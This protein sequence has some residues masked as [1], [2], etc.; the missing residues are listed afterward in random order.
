MSDN[1][2]K[3]FHLPYLLWIEDPKNDD[4]QPR[5]NTPDPVWASSISIRRR[6]VQQLLDDL[7][8]FLTVMALS[9][10]RV[11]TV[12]YSPSVESEWLRLNVVDN[13]Y[14]VL[15]QDA[16]DQQLGELF[17]CT[18][19][20]FS[21]IGA[22]PLESPFENG[23]NQT[24]ST[25]AGIDFTGWTEDDADLFSENLYQLM[26]LL[27]D[28]AVRT[29]R[30]HSTP[31]EAE[32]PTFKQIL[33]AIAKTVV[34]VVWFLAEQTEQ[35]L[36]APSS[37]G[38]LETYG[39]I[40]LLRPDRWGTL[41]SEE[42]RLKDEDREAIFATA[43]LLL[44]QPDRL[45]DV[46]GSRRFHG[47][48]FAIYEEVLLHYQG[49]QELFTSYPMIDLLL[50]RRLLSE[51]GLR[52]RRDG[53]LRAQ[54]Q[55]L[56]D[57]GSEVPDGTAGDM[58]K[59]FYQA[60]ESVLR[61]GAGANE[62]EAR[63]LARRMKRR[64]FLDTLLT[65]CN[66]GL[67]LETAL[68]EDPW[69]GPWVDAFYPSWENQDHIN[70]EMKGEAIYEG[71]ISL[72]REVDFGYAME[73]AV[74]WEFIE[75]REVALETAAT[76]AGES[77]EEWETG[78]FS[79]RLILVAAPGIAIHGVDLWPK[80]C[81]VEIYRVQNPNWVPTWGEEITPELFETAE[82]YSPL[83][84]LNAGTGTADGADQDQGWTATKASQW[85]FPDPESVPIVTAKP[86]RKNGRNGVVIS[87]RD[88]PGQ[89]WKGKKGTFSI[90]VSVSDTSGRQAF[91]YFI[92]PYE[93]EVE[94]TRVI[95]TEVEA[96]DFLLNGQPIV[97]D[98]P[99]T[100]T[101]VV[102][103]IG[104]NVVV[105][106]TGDTQV[107]TV[108]PATVKVKD[109][110]LESW[111]LGEGEIDPTEEVGW[112]EWMIGAASSFVNAVG[113][114]VDFFLD[115][116]LGTDPQVEDLQGVG[117]Y[118]LYTIAEEEDVHHVPPLGTPLA[119]DAAA[120]RVELEWFDPPDKPSEPQVHKYPFERDLRTLLQYRGEIF[121]E[122]AMFIADIGIGLIP[123]VGDYVDI[124]D[125]LIALTTGRDKWGRPVNNYQA[126]FILACGLVPFLASTGFRAIKASR[127][128]SSDDP[129]PPE[130]FQHVLDEG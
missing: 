108:D 63:E 22:S 77:A 89:T 112:I 17:R 14:E 87:Y 124:V 113:Q 88:K 25:A 10:W 103:V 59:S 4:V 39:L 8:P 86:Y 94:R 9:G 20:P 119:F 127:K 123:G 107:G 38:D 49:L 35:A 97:S 65:L 45:L 128:A 114:T 83:D 11:E 85:T 44:G 130:W 69:Q 15:A 117:R 93:T 12:E 6:D 58:N 36:T 56:Q 66:S 19:T 84:V 32:T 57:D 61:S 50:D 41:W 78:S 92:E 70:L 37:D 64:P 80:W 54:L 23:T 106:R 16:D 125:G 116:E 81:E 34:P 96:S 5:P 30:I 126:A 51:G 105:Y 13:T 29:V 102:T 79:A 99:E 120:N 31:T 53:R 67:I 111:W 104:F 33:Q 100:I 3:A 7:H 72:I 48:K 74:A 115:T 47:D 91:A 110:F 43:I 55:V 40:D 71:Q 73:H 118:W 24:I 90:D 76:P 18:Y 129:V 68:P 109:S 62:K 21:A 42:A 1:Q 95:A 2:L 98:T 28:Y 60:V 121:R 27:T 82:V 122:N 26:P 52:Y 46:E 75:A 101:E